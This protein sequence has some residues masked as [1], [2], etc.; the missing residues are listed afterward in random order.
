MGSLTKVTEFTFKGAHG[1][2]YDGTHLWVLGFECLIKYSWSGTCNTDFQLHNVKTFPLRGGHSLDADLS[3]PQ[4]L[5]MT[6]G[7]TV[8]RVTKAD[9]T[10]TPW[11][12]TL[13]GRALGTVGVK[14]YARFKTGE[15]LWIQAL[16]GTDP[17][18]PGAWWNHRVDFFDPQGEFIQSQTLSLGHTHTPRFYRARVSRVAFA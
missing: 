1:V 7:T 12:P 6:N 5:L 11:V 14:S 18:Q 17:N 16:A 13:G 2:W 4:F 9:G 10:V 8:G 15:S 3:D